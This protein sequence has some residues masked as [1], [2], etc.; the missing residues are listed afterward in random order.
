MQC[1]PIRFRM[2]TEDNGI[3]RHVIVR[4]TALQPPPAEL[5]IQAVFKVMSEDEGRNRLIQDDIALALD[6]GRRC[7]VLSRFKEHC[8]VF[9]DELVQRGKA[10]FLLMGDLGKK[11]R[12]SL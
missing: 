12:A 10:P 8:R 5:N 11:E 2:V 3:P 4:N 7:L 9:A 6:E 1:G